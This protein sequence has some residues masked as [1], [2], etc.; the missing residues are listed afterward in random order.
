ME[1]VSNYKVL[2]YLHVDKQGYIPVFLPP[3]YPGHH[4]RAVTQEV[5][6][7]VHD[8]DVVHQGWVQGYLQGGG[9]YVGQDPG[10]QL[11]TL[12]HHSPVVC[13]KIICLD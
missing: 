6:P 8:V 2:H 4:L 3:E 10:C 7:R 5:Q 12:T 1:E 11:Q 13:V 9:G